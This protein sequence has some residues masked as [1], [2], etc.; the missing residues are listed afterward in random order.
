M[1][2]KLIFLLLIIQYFHPTTLLSNNQEEL[3]EE[4]VFEVVVDNDICLEEDF[5]DDW[6]LEDMGEEF[7]V[8][9]DPYP[10]I[11]LAGLKVGSFLLYCC[12]QVE[13]S[14]RYSYNKTMRI[15]RVKK[16]A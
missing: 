1:Q 4:S 6:G 12:Y 14:L 11:Y 15:L 5:S 2:K 10:S 7:L 3:Q 13:K 8:A 16:E 9:A